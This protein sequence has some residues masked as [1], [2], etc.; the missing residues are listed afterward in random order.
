MASQV[1]V[2]SIFSESERRDGGRDDEREL[3][4]LKA[5]MRRVADEISRKQRFDE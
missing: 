5:A 1:P 3:R 4:C 2:T